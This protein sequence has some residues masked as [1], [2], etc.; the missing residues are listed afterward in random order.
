MNKYSTQKIVFSD[1]NLDIEKILL[2]SVQ[3]SNVLYIHSNNYP[4]ERAHSSKGYTQL[5]GIS[6]KNEYLTFIDV[7]KITKSQQKWVFGFVSYDYKNKIEKLPKPKKNEHNFPKICFFEPEILFYE[8]KDGWFYVGST[9]W[10]MLAKSIQQYS[11]NKP[12][13]K[14]TIEIKSTTDKKQYVNKVHSLQKHIQKGDIYEINFC[15][16]FYADHVLIDPL[17]TFHDLN[18]QSPNPHACFLKINKKYLMCASPERFLKKEGEKI[19]AQPIKGTSP[20]Y[21][22][23]QKDEASKQTLQNSNKERSENIMIVDLVRND[24]A[25][26]ALK[27]TVHVN[28]LCEI[29]SFPNV[30]QMIS[31]IS[32]TLKKEIQ[33]KDIFHATF[34]MGSMTG[35]PKV[36]AMQLIDEY[37]STSRNL[38]SGTVGYIDPEGNFDFN[39][40]IRSILYNQE[41][42]HLSYWVGSAITALSNPESEYEECLLKAKTIRSVLE[43]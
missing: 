18:K 3:F 22:D 6:K 1:V 13:L 24:L 7:E 25:K 15:Q 39:V 5:L 29:Y 11:P 33:F 36:K 26:I 28:E 16:H 32:C 37:E 19:Y 42:K 8:T 34:P 41:S 40:V 35:A 30:H 23:H 10:T 2:W 17:S 43:K 4:L 9:P 31:T 14:S 27:E 12:V 38:F 20:R 21:L